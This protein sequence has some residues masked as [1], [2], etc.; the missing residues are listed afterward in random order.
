MAPSGFGAYGFHFLGSQHLAMGAVPPHF[1]PGQNDLETEVTLNL[2]PHLLQQVA[3]K[4]LNLAAAQANDVSVL[5][6][7][8]RLVVVLVAVVMHQVQL[9]HQSSGLEQFQSAVD[10]YPVNFGIPLARELEETFSVQML[11]GLVDQIQ[12]N[13][14]LPC[15][16]N[17]LLFERILDTRDRHGDYH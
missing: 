14:P 7:Q 16:P 17:S 15:Q 9:V 3:E 10:G 4:F 2:L 1:G 12:Q 5:L 11:A 6:F 8:A 13:L